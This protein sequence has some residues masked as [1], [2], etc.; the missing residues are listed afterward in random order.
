MTAPDATGGTPD[1]GNR[2]QLR[3]VLRSAASLATSTVATAG[4]GFIYWAVAARSFP[5]ASVGESST[6]ISAVSLL[7]P[8]SI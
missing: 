2:S 3:F 1:T 4:I 8:L 6:D 7:A 5:A